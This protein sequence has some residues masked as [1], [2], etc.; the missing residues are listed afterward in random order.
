MVHPLSLIFPIYKLF[1]VRFLTF[2]SIF[3]C[4]HWRN[5]VEDIVSYMVLWNLLNEAR[6]KNFF[7]TYQ[8]HRKLYS[9]KLPINFASD[10]IF[11]LALAVGKVSLR[12]KYWSTYSIVWILLILDLITGL[13][14][15]FCLISLQSHFHT[16]F[17]PYFI[18]CLP[19]NLLEFF[20]VQ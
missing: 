5:I 2:N 1:Y 15:V 10:C 7:V 19:N 11:L 13:I 9:S 17:V 18:V 12:S 3:S 4:V 16:N 6:P 8:F 20:V 14:F